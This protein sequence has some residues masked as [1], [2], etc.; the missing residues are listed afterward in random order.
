MGT[1]FPDSNFSYRIW[2]RSLH[3]KAYFDRFST[4]SEIIA[5]YVNTLRVSNLLFYETTTKVSKK[6]PEEEISSPN[7]KIATHLNH[8]IL[9]Q[10]TMKLFVENSGIDSL[11]DSRIAG[12]I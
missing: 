5:A 9:L 8:T 4:N 10:K 12:I 6:T 11:T 2:P 3:V 1:V 7:I